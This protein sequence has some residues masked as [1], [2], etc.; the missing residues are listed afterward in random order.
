MLGIKQYNLAAV[1]NNTNL[2]IADFIKVYK[3]FF[4]LC[5]ENHSHKI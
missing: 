5:F 1:E 3:V 4:G 2:H